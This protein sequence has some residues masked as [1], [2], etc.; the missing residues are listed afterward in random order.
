MRSSDKRYYHVQ[1]PKRSAQ[2]YTV[3][4]VKALRDA[5]LTGERG[6]LEAV[7]RDSAVEYPAILLACGITANDFRRSFRRGSAG[8]HNVQAN[9]LADIEALR[10]ERLDG[11]SVMRLTRE[12]HKSV[13]D[14]SE[15]LRAGDRLISDP[16]G[17]LWMEVLVCM[18]AGQQDDHI[19]VL[20]GLRG[21]GRVMGD[22]SGYDIGPSPTP[23]D[24]PDDLPSNEAVLPF[25][26]RQFLFYRN[27]TSGR[28]D[29]WRG[30]MTTPVRMLTAYLDNGSMMVARYC[31]GDEPSTHEH[32][33]HFMARV[34]RIDVE[35]GD[36][37]ASLAAQWNGLRPERL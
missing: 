21:Q 8:Y 16:Q 22:R 14:K 15:K 12:Q 17:K 25:A 5:R 37:L 34:E 36:R 32:Q 9:N 1:R 4:I 35:L 7:I 18:L 31:R 26:A 23:H 30:L 33:R 28:W 3:D 6:G 2:D 24:L 20:E 11:Y 19:D 13:K 10:A 29:Q 27:R